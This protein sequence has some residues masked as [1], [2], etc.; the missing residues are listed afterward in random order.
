[1]DKG[2]KCQAGQEESPKEGNIRKSLCPNSVFISQFPFIAQ[3]VVQA[4]VFVR[5]A[6]L[7]LFYMPC[8]VN[9]VGKY[10]CVNSVEVLAAGLRDLKACP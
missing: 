7:C 10:F 6:I 1:M 3:L 5:C 2:T 8:K 9:H 4:V